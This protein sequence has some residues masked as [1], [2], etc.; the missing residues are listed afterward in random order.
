MGIYQMNEQKVA[1]VTGSSKGIGQAIAQRLAKDGFIVVVH[2]GSDK[3][4]AEKTQK[5]IADGG[6]IA[7]LVHGDLLD[8]QSAERIFNEAMSLAGGIDVLANNAGINI[9]RKKIFDL[10]EFDFDKVM[11]LNAKSV[12][13]F[14]KQA[15]KCLRNSG[16]II[17]VSTSLLAAPEPGLAA[18]VSSK[19]VVEALTR[20][21]A[22]ELAPRNITVN[23]VAPGPVDTALFRA[24]KTEDQIRAAAALSP[25]NRVGTVEEVAHVV[26]FLASPGASWVTGQIVRSSGGMC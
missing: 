23:A 8:P 11:Q 4:S 10:E 22:L 1:L 3:K 15:A 24:G 21:L 5:D 26:S 25:F 20:V 16:R 9:P 17:S 19:A 6:G 18:Y 2:Y 12:F 7:H 14:M 13:M